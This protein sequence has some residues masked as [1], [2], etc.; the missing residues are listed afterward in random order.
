MKPP[1]QV[2]SK[3]KKKVAFFLKKKEKSLIFYFVM[4]SSLAIFDFYQNYAIAVKY[5]HFF[6]S[7]ESFN[8]FG[9]DMR[10]WRFAAVFYRKD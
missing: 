10:L 5:N 7:A 1:G 4:T 6:S 9:R 2:S 8:E 3:Q